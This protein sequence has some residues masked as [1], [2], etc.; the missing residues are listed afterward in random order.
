MFKNL[1]GNII[2]KLTIFLFIITVIGFI[3]QPQLAK[4][5][6]HGLSLETDKNVYALG[7]NI[8]I[9]LTNN[10]NETVDIGGYPAW[11]ILIHPEGEHVCPVIYAFLRWELS[12]GENDTFVWDQYNLLNFTFVEPG[13]YVLKDVQRWGLVSSFEIVAAEDIV[14]EFPSAIILSLFMVF[15]MLIA[16]LAKKYDEKH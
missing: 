4:A 16:I 8:T 6:K 11:E 3:F 1:K 15:P 9:I 12:P 14:P 7:E 2:L 5:E 13:T 10:G